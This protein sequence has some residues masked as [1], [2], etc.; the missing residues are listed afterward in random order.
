MVKPFSLIELKQIELK[1]VD[2]FVF[3]FPRDL[4]SPIIIT[5]YPNYTQEELAFAITSFVIE[6]VYNYEP[7]VKRFIG[8]SDVTYKIE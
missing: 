3:T 2:K 4:S 8:F 6:Y 5:T 7:R 1:F